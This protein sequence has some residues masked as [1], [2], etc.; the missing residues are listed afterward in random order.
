MKDT[1]LGQLVLVI[2]LGSGSAAVTSSLLSGDEPQVVPQAPTPSVDLVAQLDDLRAENAKLSERIADLELRPEPSERVAAVEDTEFEEEV[3]A[4]MEQMSEKEKASPVAL[5]SKVEDALTS[6]RQQEA[7]QKQQVK[8]QQRDEWITS[9]IEKIAPELGLT[10]YQA[11]EMQLTWRARA[12]M[13]A[14][15]AR[16]WQA[17]EIDSQQAGEIKTAN[18][19]RHQAN[20]QAFLSAEQYETYSSNINRWLGRGK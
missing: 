10:Q 5:Q 8:D 14:E 17:G 3:R 4:F 1:S 13:D 18:N 7:I 16:L 20:L 15:L 9:R 12:E 11:D 2:L 19:E 6:I